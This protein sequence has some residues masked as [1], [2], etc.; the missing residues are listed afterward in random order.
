MFYAMAG[1]IVLLILLAVL[2]LLFVARI[3]REKSEKSEKAS[4][5]WDVDVEFDKV[6]S[7]IM[8]KA[9]PFQEQ[10]KQER[11]A[12]GNPN[13]SE[14]GFETEKDGEETINPLYQAISSWHD[15]E[16]EVSPTVRPTW[17]DSKRVASSTPIASYTAISSN[18]EHGGK[19]NRE[20]IQNPMYSRGG[21]HREHIQNPVY[22]YHGYHRQRNNNIPNPFYSSLSENH[23]LPDVWVASDRVF[24]NVNYTPVQVQEEDLYSKIPESPSPQDE[25]DWQNDIYG[26]PLAHK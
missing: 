11:T 1:A 5:D 18:K 24:N 14:V 2:L 6:M 9:K 7:A 12:I 16:P 20:H 13:Y 8:G 25:E 4:H 17:T 3:K 10:L 19:K 15:V 26:P 22:S 21:K 23:D